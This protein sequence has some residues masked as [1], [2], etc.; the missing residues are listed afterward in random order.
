MT[1]PVYCKDC[2]FHKVSFGSCYECFKHTD[3]TNFI[4]PYD[5]P[6]EDFERKEEGE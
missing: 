2:K 3:T 6:C 4:N 1:E 5:A